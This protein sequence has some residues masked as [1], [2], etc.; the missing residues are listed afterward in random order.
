MSE[1]EATVLGVY[2]LGMIVVTV[3]VGALD[4]YQDLDKDASAAMFISLF[5][6]VLAGIFL[7]YAPFW[8][9]YWCGR[10]LFS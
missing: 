7:V 9:L 8:L 3:V 5:W 6:P 2:V 1:Q 10:K 4:Q